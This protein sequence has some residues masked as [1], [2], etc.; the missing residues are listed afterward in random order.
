M[1]NA[2]TDDGARATRYHK[3]HAN[4]KAI[5][6]TLI[7]LGVDSLPEST[8]EVILDFDA[9]D[10]LIHGEQEGWF[11]NGDYR[12]YCYLPLYCFVGSIPFFANLGTSDRDACEGTVEALEIIVPILRKR[13][14]NVRIILRGDSGFAR[15]AIMKWCEENACYYVLGMGKNSRLIKMLGHTFRTP[16]DIPRTIN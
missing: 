15:D 8:E 5:E 9:T 3:I 11:Y 7:E 10:D 6:K 2:K 13:F 4:P 14:P 12:N 1:T 16:N